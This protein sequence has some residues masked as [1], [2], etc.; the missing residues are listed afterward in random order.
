MFRKHIEGPTHQI[1]LSEDNKEVEARLMVGVCSMGTGGK[2][3]AD[4]F[5]FG[6]A[7][8]GK[9]SHVMFNSCLSQLYSLMCELFPTSLTPR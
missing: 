1:W 8:D 7:E 3:L 5:D 4:P 2:F 9:I 6:F